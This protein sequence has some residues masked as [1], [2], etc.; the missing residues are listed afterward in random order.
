M[1]ESQLDLFAVPGTEPKP[2]QDVESLNNTIK[3]LEANLRQKDQEVDNYRKS[4]AKIYNVNQQL[5]ETLW[6][7]RYLSANWHWTF[8]LY[9]Q[10][11]DSSE[12]YRKEMLIWEKI[13]DK[14]AAYCKDKL[15]RDPNTWK[16]IGE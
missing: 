15:K 4:W 6:R 5:S 9:A 12:E 16:Y 2:S 8:L 7:Y 10:T 11:G 13:K 14:V 1:S 3:R